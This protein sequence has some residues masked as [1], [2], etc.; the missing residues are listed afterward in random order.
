ME[1][2]KEPAH[3][4]IVKNR[5]TF[6][7]EWRKGA[8]MTLEQLA[9]RIEMTAS[10][11][12]MLERGQ[13]AYTQETLRKI[14]EALGCEPQDLLMRAPDGDSFWSVWQQATPD[15]RETITAVAKEITRRRG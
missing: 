10:H 9:E 8:H 12:S 5:R 11:L 13:R 3:H 15:Q 1:C 7:R 14:V 2:G 4:L 6:I